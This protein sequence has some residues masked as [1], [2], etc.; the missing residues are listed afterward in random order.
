MYC[1]LRSFAKNVP[2][3]WDET[4]IPATDLKC[5]PPFQAQQ[6]PFQ[7]HQPLFQTP[8]PPFQTEYPGGGQ[9]SGASLRPPSGSQFAVLRRLGQETGFILF[10]SV[11]FTV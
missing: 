6:P 4:T 2:N 8:Q 7:T 11:D 3:E 5:S 10:K 1:T 9:S